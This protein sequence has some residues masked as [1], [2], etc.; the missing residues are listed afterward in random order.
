MIASDPLLHLVIAL[1]LALLFLNAASH[2]RAAPRRFAAQLDAYRLLPDALAARTAAGLPWLEIAAALLL[3]PAASRPIGALLAATLLV[4]YSAAMA[5]NLLR[6]GRDIDC[7]CGGDAQP[8]SWPLVLR[9]LLLTM[10]A[11]LLLTPTPARPLHAIDAIVAGALVAVL[12]LTW[13]AHHELARNA[14]AFQRER[15]HES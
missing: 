6:G 7:G 9:N 13:G 11:T 14:A 1:A 4:A 10:S 12:A 15:S 2:K 3:L 8:L 5:V